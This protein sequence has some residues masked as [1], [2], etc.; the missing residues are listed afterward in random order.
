MGRP[1]DPRE[2]VPEAIAF[3]GAC[4]EQSPWRRFAPLLA[5]ERVRETPA[6]REAFAESAE[7]FT[8]DLARWSFAAPGAAALFEE[9]LLAPTVVATWYYRLCR[10]LFLRDVERVPYVLAALSRWM[11]GVE[12]YFSADI[13]PGLKVI[14]GVG[15]V[16]GAACRIGSQFTCYQGVTLGDK[17]LPET[18]LAARPVIGDH[19]VIA[20]GA[21]VLGPVRIGDYTLVAA[22]AVVLDSLPARC[23]AAGA[24]AAV[25]GSLDEARIQAIRASIK[26]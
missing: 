20:A 14:H 16:I 17:I 9:L 3:A 7:I 21:A 25:R 5:P 26:G 18:G 12:I 11:S 24:P 8:Q 4:L 23:I 2:L 6:L 15:A 22:N 19:V 10:A 1:Y 13:G